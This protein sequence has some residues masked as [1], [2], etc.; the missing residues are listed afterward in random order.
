[1]SNNPESIELEKIMAREAKG[2]KSE[3]GEL[4]LTLVV[5]ERILSEGLINPDSKLSEAMGIIAD[6]LDK[7][8]EI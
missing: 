7:L 4:S 8:A 3:K 2:V 5:L 1:M 6:E